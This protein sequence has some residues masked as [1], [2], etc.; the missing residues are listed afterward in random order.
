MWHEY[1]VLIRKLLIFKDKGNMHNN[2]KLSFLKF[3]GPLIQVANKRFQ[4]RNI[5]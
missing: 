4:V 5:R 3:E 2:L 1:T